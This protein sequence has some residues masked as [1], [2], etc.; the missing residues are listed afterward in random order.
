MNTQTIIWTALPNGI[1]TAAGK[2]HLRISLLVSPRLSSTSTARLTLDPAFP[3]FLHWANKVKGMK[4]T[5]EFEGRP[6][7]TVSPLTEPL[8]DTLWTAIF[9][10]TTQVEPYKIPD[11][12][13]LQIG[14]YPVRNITQRIK[15]AY[16]AIA[17]NSPVVLPRASLEGAALQPTRALLQDMVITPQVR[18]Q[19]SRGLVTRQQGTQVRALRNPSYTAA[20]SLGSHAEMKPMS[21]AA[22]VPAVQGVSEAQ[23]DFHQFQD[24]HAS[25]VGPRQAMPTPAALIA[26]IDFH[27]IVAHLQQYPL[28]MRKLGLVVDLEIPWDEKL[29]NAGWVR[30]S[31]VGTAE[32]AKPT[33]APR[34]NIILD[35]KRFVAKPRSADSDVTDGMLQLND[36]DRFEI[37]EVDVDGAALKM[38]EVARQIMVKPVFRS[39]ALA[40]AAATPGGGRPTPAPAAPSDEEA[41]PLPSLR[42]AGLWVARVNRAAE[43]AQVLDRLVA[44]N[45]AVDGK[46]SPDVPLFAEDLV[47][48]YRVDVWDQ[49]AGKWFSLCRRVGT[50][51]FLEPSKTLTLEDEGWV[52]SAAVESA[53][54]P[55][56]IYVHETMF[57][58]E[59]WSLVA[60]RPGKPVENETGVPAETD[61]FGVQVSF[62]AK[63]GSLPRLRFGREYRMRARMVDL[64]GN[65]LSL[66]EAGDAAATP[67]YT[68]FRTEPVPPPVVIPRRPLDDSPGESVEIIAIRSRN[69]APA[70]DDD[71][72]SDTSQRHLAPPRTSELMAETHGEFD[73]DKTMKG[74]PI[75]YQLIVGKDVK[76]APYYDVDQL[77]LPYLPDPM[78]FGMMVRLR[79]M[80]SSGPPPSATTPPPAPPPPPP[81][82]P[83][84]P[85]G[86][87]Q[88]L[89]AAGGFGARYSAKALIAR[90][91]LLFVE[92]QDQILQIP[93]GEDWPDLKPVRLVLYEPKVATEKMAFVEA[94][95][96]LRVP[97]AKGE[98]AE[99]WL[100][101]YLK[102]TAL[103]QLQMWRWTVEGVAAPT[104]RKANLAPADAL[105]VHR[106]LHQPAALAQW[107]AKVSLPQASVQSLQKLAG[108]AQQG[109]HWLTTPFRQLTLV[110]ATQQPLGRPWFQHLVAAKSIGQTF[111]ALQGDVLVSGKSTVKLEILAEW[112]EPVDPVAEPKPRDKH[113]GKPIHG[114]AR[115]GEMHVERDDATL[116]LDGLP[117][118]FHDTKYRHV[119]YR[120]V[121][122]TRYAEYFTPPPK[123]PPAKQPVFTRSSVDREV[124]VLSSA[125]PLA[126]KVMYVI[127]AFAWQKQ[128]SAT[129]ATS[130]R[131][132]GWLRVY[133]ERPWYSSGDGELLGV[134]VGPPPPSGLGTMVAGTAGADRLKSLVTQ[135]GQ[136][137]LWTA[138]G[139]RAWPEV[140]DFKVA[141]ATE[142]GLS[143]EEAPGAKVSVV[144]YDVAYDEERQ[145]WYADLQIDCGDAY[146]PFIRLALARYQPKSVSGPDGDVKLSRVVLADFAQLAPDRAVTLTFDQTNK[147]GIGVSVAGPTYTGSAAAQGPSE[148]VVTLEEKT[149]AVADAGTWTPVP[150]YQVALTR[151]ARRG[152]GPVWS[153]DVVLPAARGDNKYRLVI[154]EYETF[155]ADAPK[156][157]T[158]GM[159]VVD[160]APVKRVVYA[161]VLEV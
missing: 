32:A 151:S 76:P 44:L 7:L 3:D 86:G 146:Y 137:P 57:R 64:A 113:S 10:P 4:F 105:Q 18:T 134:V 78:A 142:A 99:I 1:E 29:A 63:P 28:L 95:R 104:V 69:D 114:Q 93:F 73:G 90:P 130:T 12:A 88:M 106:Q 121:V 49:Q 62:A 59:G 94:N 21:A 79:M 75:T 133:L 101:C 152:A 138:P 103:P 26:S 72:I 16:Q 51:K 80:P 60:P 25:L 89:R 19:I 108:Q 149:G 109:R 120:A 81:P 38:A 71:V 102:P 8:D 122:T 126:P 135:W 112:D 53:K 70:K 15:E 118:E 5:V 42:S 139:M 65:S 77:P 119:T 147:T 2:T 58:W 74:G 34:T 11:V 33:V 117:H 55:N 17:I 43:L 158:L 111:A 20:S 56:K 31:P 47:R 84:P 131:S 125:R 107:S 155:L 83:A 68:Y 40:T 124:D 161:D 150:D 45:Q 129:G 50:Y 6:P 52:S 35:K 41:A 159:M 67:P 66:E 128:D 82:P 54:E 157:A 140:G 87:K 100:S 30:V 98:A 160:F 9:K 13:K 91:N 36:T 85:G 39:A 110:H 97:L 144:G 153:G 132:G 154:K 148:M 24:F 145:L 14:S 123:T 156:T 22:A 115:V 23:V 141:Q 61:K 116:A 136:D 127:P 27:E 48:G 37:G 96:T 143:L 46:Q 92:P